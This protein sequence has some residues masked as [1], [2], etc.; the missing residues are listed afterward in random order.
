MNKE[1]KNISDKEKEILESYEIEEYEFT[2]EAAQEELE[3]TPQEEVLEVFEE[4]PITEPIISEIEEPIKEKKSHKKLFTIIGIILVIILVPTI[5]IATD[6]F[7]VTKQK[8]T[9]IFAI[10]TKT[11]KDGGTKE[12]TGLGYKVIK[13]NQK[14]GRRDIEI[15]NWGLKYNSDILEAEAIDLAIKFTENEADSYEEYKGKFM[16]ISGVLTNVSMN[17]NTITI[18]YVDEDGKYNFDILCDMATKK[19]KLTEFETN[20]RITAIGTVTN[21]D[22]KSPENNSTLHLS[23]CFAEQE[24]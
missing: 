21:Y 12:Y 23:N 17:D 10:V 2:E 24:L 11:H 9:P 5:M 7:R 6:I 16:R 4:E 19:D 1:N 3:N 8:K 18:S 13:Y 14:Q 20:I 15:G 22:Y